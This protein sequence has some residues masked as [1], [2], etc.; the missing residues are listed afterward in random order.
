[1]PN[2]SYVPPAVENAAV[3]VVTTPTGAGQSVGLPRVNLFCHLEHPS[4]H[5][6]RVTGGRCETQWAVPASSYRA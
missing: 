3:P 2:L 5:F 1:M 6:F 4:G